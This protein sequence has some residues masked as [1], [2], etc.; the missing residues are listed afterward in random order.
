[1]PTYVYEVIREEGDDRPAERFEVVQS[2]KDDALT[3]HPETGAP[4]RRVILPPNIPVPESQ[5]S[6]AHAVD[7]DRRLG[8][9]GFTKYVK[10]GDGSYE[11]KAGKGPGRIHRDNL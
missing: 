10:S 11:K 6:G 5:Q 3:R 1:M 7:N 2:M 9:L 4:V 8:E